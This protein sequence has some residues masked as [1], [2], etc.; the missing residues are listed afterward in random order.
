MAPIKAVCGAICSPSSRSVAR[1]LAGKWT[2]RSEISQKANEFSGMTLQEMRAEL[3][4]RAKRLGLANELA[5]LLTEDG[6]ASL[7]N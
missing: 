1:K 3:I 7:A 2:E 5:D 4:R 6:D